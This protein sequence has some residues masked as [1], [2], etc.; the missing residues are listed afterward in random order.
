MPTI[1]DVAKAAGV[2]KS[3]VSN[4]FSQ[5]RPISQEVRERVLAVAK[6]LNY[7]PNYLARSLAIK[8]TK[9]IGLNMIGEK[10]KFN[11]FHLSFINGVLNECYQNDYRL[12]IN[13]LSD[14]YK[15]QV[16]NLSSDP[17]DG[18]I[19]LNPSRE[20]ARIQEL[21]ENNIP[22]VVVG[23]PPKPFEDTVPS[24]D[25]NNSPAAQQAT[26]YLLSLGHRHILFCN[27]PKKRT[28]SI[29]REKGYEYAFSQ[30][31][32]SEHPT[33]ITY[34]DETITSIEFGYQ[35]AMTM[36]HKHPEISAVITDNDK[37]ALGFYRAC[38]ELGLSIPEDLSVIAFSDGSMYSNELTPTLTSMT[39]NGETLGLEATKL[40]LEQLTKTEKVIKRVMVQIK[41]HER[42]SCAPPGLKGLKN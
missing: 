16:I 24:V 4:V 33:Y 11:Q 25:N 10:I 41:L 17:T 3:T 6:E 12:L 21:F 32:L 26:E 36:L 9:I 42:E 30:A 18:E 27:A 2:S 5:K 7:R 8:E 29:D 15:Q 34:R 37:V 22:L 35:T 40:L 13:T 23:R 19:I 39:L 20:D 1:N 31:G 38:N 14:D 28:V